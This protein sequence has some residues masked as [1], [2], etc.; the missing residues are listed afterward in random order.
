MLFSS[1]TFL[2]YFLP[3]TLVAYFVTPRPKGSQKYRNLV[4]L[5]ASLVFYAWG[6]P[7]YIALMAAQCVSAWAL[8][9]LI[10]RYRGRR[11][12]LGFTILSVVLGFG[13]LVFFKYTDF[14]IANVNALLH[15]KLGLLGLALP[16]GISFYTFHIQ[17]YTIDLYRGKFVPQ[18]N[19]LTFAT[20]V[21]M[22]PALVA[23]PIVRYPTVER[24]LTA[25]DASIDRFATGARRFVMGLAKKVLIANVMGELV[26]VYKVS[27]D[28]S[29]LFAWLY[30]VA[31]ALQIYFDFSGY[32]DM[33]LGLARI[34][35]FDLPENFNYPYIAASITDFW[36]RW[37]ISM[38]SW[39]RDYVYIPLGGNRVS[40]PRHLV[41]ILVVWALTGLWHGAAWNFVLWGM[42]FAVLLI[43]EKYVLS[44]VLPKLPQWA[45]H[46]YAM[47][48]V[49]VSWVIFDADGLASIGS[50]LAHLVGVGTSGLAGPEALYY[51]RSYAVPIVVAVFGCTPVLKRVATRLAAHRAFTIIEPVVVGALLI[52]ATAYL[53]DGS[54][55]PFIYFRF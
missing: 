17:S 54:F 53:V 50:T 28:T 46:A 45:R 33:A 10:Y 12:S 8:G 18:R 7:A 42:Y 14:L 2:Y 51:L 25:R 43:V 52:L 9:F 24:Q 5:L 30:V 31:F 29:V 34:F 32:S 41:N 3:V 47:V 26:A 4:L 40:V 55:N 44:R 20:Y 48:L 16:I 35:G 22:F 21:A 27:A 36:R 23:G 15:S 11:V 38:S 39:F 6:E 1:I 19:L 13:G 49:A 37:H